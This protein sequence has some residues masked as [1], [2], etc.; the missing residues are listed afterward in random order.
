MW[1]RTVNFFANCPKLRGGPGGGRADGRGAQ[2]RYAR[3][4]RA[5]RV[6]ARTST[7]PRTGIPAGPVRTLARMQG[8]W[9]GWLAPLLPARCAVCVCVCVCVCAVQSI[10]E[11]ILEY[12]SIYLSIYL[13]MYL[14]ICSWSLPCQ[15][16]LCWS[17]PCVC[18]C[19]FITAVPM[20]K[21]FAWGDWCECVC[22]LIILHLF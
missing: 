7:H 17:L 19:V 8:R 10:F 18:V 22:L 6:C 4:S 16:C 9:G 11:S 1:G 12:L 2:L 13:R 21:L 5:F 14:S 3:G 20:K 15:R